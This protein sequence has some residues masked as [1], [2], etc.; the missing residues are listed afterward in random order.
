MMRVGMP[1]NS[2]WSILLLVAGAYGAL[3]LVLF[4]FQS[5]LLYLPN[6]PSRDVIATPERVGLAYEPVKIVTDDGVTLDGWFVP[7][8]Q[9]RGVLLF[10]HGN[11]GNI[12]HRLDSLK[13]FND[14]GLA[15]LIFDYRGYGRSHGKPSEQGTYRDAE[16]VWR[17]VTEKRHTAVQDIVLF[18]RSLGAAIA[19]HLATEHTPKALI[20]ESAFTSIPDLAAEVYPFLPARWLARFRY[21]TEAHLQ[22]V[23]CPVLVVHS[24]DDEIIPFAHGRRLFAVANEPKQLLEIRGGHNDGFVV[25][26]QAYVDGL[27]TFM[28]AHLGQ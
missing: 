12:S 10:F 17:Y 11:A 3:L 6:L 14:L 28:R 7:V 18:G 16:A 2:V 25:S 4:F 5:R 19:V 26:R 20:I 15:T 27:D 9:A 8:R 23:S 1:L 13:L 22:S 24:R 21:S